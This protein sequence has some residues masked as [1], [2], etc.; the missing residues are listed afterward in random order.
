MGGGAWWF[1]SRC[2]DCWVREGERSHGQVLAA[3]RDYELQHF[4]QN[5]MCRLQHT[6][7][8][9]ITITITIIL[10]VMIMVI[11]IITTNTIITTCMS[12]SS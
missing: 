5:A 11:I 10:T 1:E 6:N 2:T 9:N 8:T 4:L 12:C 7:I 3:V